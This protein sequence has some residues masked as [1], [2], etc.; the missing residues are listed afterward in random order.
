MRPDTRAKISDPGARYASPSQVLEDETLTTEDKIDVLNAFVLDAKLLASVGTEN[1]TTPG[2]LQDATK[3]LESLQ[4][5]QQTATPP[6]KTDAPVSQM[7]YRKILVAL[8]TD[9]PLVDQILETAREMARLCQAKIRFLTVV[10]SAATAVPN[11]AY[12]PAGAAAVLPEPLE[13][14]N[15]QLAEH[16]RKNADRLLASFAPLGNGRHAIRRGICDDEIVRYASEWPADLLIM[17]SHKQGWLEAL[18]R[19][20]TTRAV[21]NRIGCAVLLVPDSN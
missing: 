5:A 17:G 7:S 3:A 4:D 16:H 20:S 1:D 12:G 14:A 15:E 8:D 18:F 2:L 13:Q 10:P 11:V 6:R 9:D 19:D 21:I